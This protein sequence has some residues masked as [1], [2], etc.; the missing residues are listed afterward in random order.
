MES[1]ETVLPI[2]VDWLERNKDRNDW[3]LHIH[4]WDPHT[5]YRVPVEFGNPF[6]NEPLHD[7]WITEDVFKSHLSKAGPH[8]AKDIGGLDDSV[9]P[10]YP[11]HPGSLSNLTDVKNIIDLYDCGIYYADYLLGRVLGLLKEQNIYD[12]TAIIISSDHGENMGELGLYAEHGTADNITCR[13]PMIIKWPKG[14]KGR[15][16]NLRYNL[17]LVPTT[18]EL[19]GLPFSKKWDGD[20]YAEV[21]LEGKDELSRGRDSIVLSQQAHV[22][23]R[24]A[25]FGDWIY[26]RTIRDG[27][28]LFDDEMLYN[29]KD[30]PHEQFDLKD[31]RPDLCAK[32]AKI[33]L[34]WQE[35]MMKTADVDI[36]P[37]W[38]VYH[39]GGP[40]HAHDN[41]FELYMERLENSA[42]G[43]AAQKLRKRYSTF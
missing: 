1:G 34:D 7:N 5:P 35:K 17:D 21:I 11:R 9:D 33:I 32:G 23:Q 8:S 29:L 25:R 24:S 43:D 22:C 4:I 41:V 2:A 13:I 14:K 20:S 18:A 37:M 12:D 31:D 16:S 36:D 39:E 3:F 26:I 10:K 6:E 19:L 38:T 28:H 42:R 40:Y 30:D 15:D 27:F